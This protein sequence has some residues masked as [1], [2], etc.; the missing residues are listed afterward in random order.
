MSK[1]HEG[2]SADS[3]PRYN[4]VINSRVHTKAR[5]RR[6]NERKMVENSIKINENDGK[7]D[8]EFEKLVGMSVLCFFEHHQIERC[9]LRFSRGSKSRQKKR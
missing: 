2:D 4:S 1:N 3:Y 6:K 7:N 8:D 5:S 9:D